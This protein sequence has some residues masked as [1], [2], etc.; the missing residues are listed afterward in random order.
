M[1]GEPDLSIFLQ[2]PASTLRECAQSLRGGSLRHGVTAGLLQPL[3]GSKAADVADQLGK[4]T[5]LGCPPPVLAALADALAASQS[6]TED[7]LRS[8]FPVL[9]GPSVPGVPVIATPTIVRGLFE[10]AMSKVLV[11]SYVFHDAKD[12][13]APLADRMD[14]DPEFDVTIITDLSHARKNDEP[15]PVLSNRVKQQFLTHSWPGQRTPNLWHDPRALLNPD[16][17]KSGVMHAKTVI[18]DESVAFVTSA[19]FTEAAQHRNIEAGVIIR[20]RAHVEVFRRYFD[21]LIQIGQFK[22][23]L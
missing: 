13:L 19:N 23:L 3:F 21:G 20:H 16:R 18:I 6:T 1:S 22:K 2:F 12:L 15:V 17:S 10:E 11:S 4:L 7:A 14:A 9:S 5:S 8:V